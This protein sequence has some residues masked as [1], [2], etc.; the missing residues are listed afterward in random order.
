ML[1]FWKARLLTREGRLSYVQT[2]MTASAIYHLLALDVDPWVFQ[3][4]DRIRRGF[5]WAGRK[6]ARGGCSLVAWDRVCQPKL[7]GGLGLHNLHWLSAALRARWIWFQRTSDYKPWSGLQVD[8]STDA[9]GLYQTTT[10]IVV[11]SGEKILFWTDPWINGHS[12]ATVNNN[13]V[14]DIVG[15]LMIDAVVQFL[16]LWPQVQSIATIADELDSFSWKFSA[17]GA[18]STRE[19]YLACFAG[20]TALPAAR[21]VWSSFAPLKYKFFGWL[22]IQDRC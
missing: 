7:L 18:Y 22:A 1:P 13:W 5:L 10:R 12:A 21:E 6:D 2:V 19:T 14:L 11:G 17:S 8:V 3:V 16:Q 15:P 20:R 4:V 9:Q